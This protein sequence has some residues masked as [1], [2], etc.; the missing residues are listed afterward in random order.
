MAQLYINTVTATSFKWSVQSLGSAFTSANYSSVGIARN[1]F[2]SGTSTRPDVLTYTQAFT[3]TTNTNSITFTHG[4]SAGTYTLYGFAASDGKYWSCGSVTITIPSSDTTAP[5]ISNLY[6][7]IPSHGWMNSSTVTFGASI[8]DY[9]SGVYSVNCTFNGQE[10]TSYSGVNGEYTMSFNIPT[11]AGSYT[12]TWASRDK[13]GN[14]ASKSATY[15]IGY[16]NT[17]PTINSTDI[18]STGN[19]IRTGVVGKDSGSGIDNIVFK[20]SPPGTNGSF[21]QAKTYYFNQ[22]A[23]QSQYH[24]FTVDGSGNALSLGKTYYVEI[25]VMDLVGNYVKQVLSVVHSYAKPNAW[26]WQDYELNAFNGKGAFSTLTYQRWNSFCDYI[27]QLTSWYYNDSTDTYKL[28]SAKVSESN[29]TLTA[30]KFNIVK[31]AIGSMNP[32]GISNVKAGDIVYGHYF[33]TLAEKANS[34]KK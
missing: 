29:K 20:I 11:V 5:T 17:K 21:S 13:N 31:N 22:S 9:G 4:L 28:A 25:T 24:S 19:S 27:L 2:T 12:V 15:W 10:K 30:T 1:S 18:S 6:S 34:I 14:L 23:S 16:D 26:S 7:N 32:T 33:I 8:Y 3:G